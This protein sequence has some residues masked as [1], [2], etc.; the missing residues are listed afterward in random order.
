MLPLHLWL[1]GCV[2]KLYISTVSWDSYSKDFLHKQYA[3]HLILDPDTDT[4]FLLM[5]FYKKGGEAEIN[6]AACSFP[7]LQSHHSCLCWVTVTHQSPF[8]SSQ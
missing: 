1:R 6:S 4:K 5:L 7:M 8:L 3:F 2:L